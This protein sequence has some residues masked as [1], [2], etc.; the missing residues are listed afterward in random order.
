[1]PFC[2]HLNSSHADIYLQTDNC[3]FS[4]EHSST[5]ISLCQTWGWVSADKNNHT[6]KEV[7]QISPHK[8][9]R[10]YSL[11]R[12]PTLLQ[13]T[14]K[15][16]EVE[17]MQVE[18]HAWPQESSAQIFPICFHLV[19]APCWQS[20]T[21]HGTQLWSLFQVPLLPPCWSSSSPLH[22]TC[23]LLRRSL[24]GLLRR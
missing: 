18:G 1:M 23:G 22:S 14:F 3:L 17:A 16:P 4:P 10:N 9:H 12:N 24:W 2:P 15:P 20:V 13:G 21:Q 7:A 19:G 8:T 11:N 6:P 5:W